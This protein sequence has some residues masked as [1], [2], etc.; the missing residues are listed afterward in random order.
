MLVALLVLQSQAFNSYVTNASGTIMTAESSFENIPEFS[1]FDNWET[2]S[3]WD[4]LQIPGSGT[5]YGD[6]TDSPVIKGICTL[7]SNSIVNNLTI[8]PA[9]QLNISP[10]Y[11]LTVNGAI[12]NNAGSEGLVLK[13]TL[14]GTGSL[15]QLSS[16]IFPELTMILE[17]KHTILFLFQ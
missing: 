5:A 2:A 15:M 10:N 3:K 12:S 11:G 17:Q 8:N 13:S 4:V 16:A 14:A 6:A 9:Q 7:N 1:G